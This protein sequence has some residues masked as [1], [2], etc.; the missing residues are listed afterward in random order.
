MRIGV[1]RVGGAGLR[2]AVR[3]NRKK[4]EKKEKKPEP[5]VLKNVTILMAWRVLQAGCM[6]EKKSKKTL[7]SQKRRIE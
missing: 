6:R 1:V 7:T 5:S 4:R 3:G 2:V